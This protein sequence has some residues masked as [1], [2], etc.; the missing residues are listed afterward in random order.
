MRKFAPFLVFI[1]LWGCSFSNVFA[2]TEEDKIRE[3][4]ALEITLSDM[5]KK[6][7]AYYGKDG[8]TVPPEFDE[9][10]FFAVLEKV[11][12]DKGKVE[13]IK[14]NY[15]TRAHAID[16]DYSVVLCERETG[17]KLMEDFS[18]TLNKVDIRYWD[19]TIFNACEFEQE[20][21]S[22]CK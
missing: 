10:E 20:W 8:K 4:S 12:P 14:E 2:K 18:C 13:N 6:I 21:K 1:I 15:K 19:K 11:Y 22:Y 5:S 7:I 17:N 9:K 3:Y 16:V